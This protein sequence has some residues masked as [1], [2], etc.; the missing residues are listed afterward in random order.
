M[1]MMVIYGVFD[2]GFVLLKVVVVED[3]V[4]SDQVFRGVGIMFVVF[5]IVYCVGILLVG[6]CFG[7]YKLLK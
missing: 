7:Y 6:K 3:L 2:S 5:G 4:G 1:G